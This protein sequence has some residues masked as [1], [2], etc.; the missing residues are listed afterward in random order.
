MEK[1]SILTET[2]KHRLKATFSVAE[3]FMSKATECYF[4]INK[5]IFPILFVWYIQFTLLLN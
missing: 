2:E 4:R 5:S 3:D 1:P